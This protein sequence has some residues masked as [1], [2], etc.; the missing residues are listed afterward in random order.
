MNNVLY[1]RSRPSIEKLLEGHLR[2]RALLR[3]AVVALAVEQYRAADR[4]LAGDPRCSPEGDCLASVPLDPFDGTPVKYVR[5]PDGV[6]VYAM[7]PTAGTT[8]GCP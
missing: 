1:R 6:T 7:G 2:I 4:P 5:R 3:C 8:A